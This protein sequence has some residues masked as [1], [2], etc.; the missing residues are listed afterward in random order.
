MPIACGLL[1]APNQIPICVRHCFIK[2]GKFNASVFCGG[3]VKFTCFLFMISD[4]IKMSAGVP[5]M[6]FESHLTKRQ[7]TARL[8]RRF[9]MK[10]SWH[11]GG[12]EGGKISF[13][14][15]HNSL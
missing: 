12:Q 14:I 15:P 11:F 3:P 5:L 1:R 10:N 7:F 8:L 2:I 4:K 9:L 13:N 6:W